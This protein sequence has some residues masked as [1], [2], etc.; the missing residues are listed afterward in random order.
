M[1]LYVLLIATLGSGLV[2]MMKPALGIG[3]SLDLLGLI[4]GITVLKE[5]N[6]ELIEKFTI[7]LLISVK[8]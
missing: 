5:Q 3:S 6:V 8:R 2:N 1:H 7:T 4:K